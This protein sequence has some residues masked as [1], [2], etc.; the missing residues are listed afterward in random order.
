MKLTLYEPGELS[1]CFQASL[2]ES[3]SPLKIMATTPPPLDFDHQPGFEIPTKHKEAI[4]QLHGFAGKSVEELMAR[5]QLGKSTIN[6]IL[7]YEHPERARPSRTGRPRQLTDARVDEII[8]YLSETYE[9]RCL[10]WTHLRDELELSCT[11]EW[12]ATRLKQR[13]YF[14]CTACQKPYLTA[15]QVLGR[16]LWAITHIFWT[17]EWL[18][19]LWSDEVTFLVGGRTVKQK[20]TRKK[21]E[22]DCPTCIQHQFHRGH[23]T[24]VHAW[25]AIGYG[26]K[27]PLIFIQGSGKSGAFVQR[28]YLAQVLEAHLQPI[29]EAFAAITHLLRPVAEPLFMEDGNSAHGHKST[30]NCCAKW[31]TAHGIIL[32]PH[33]SISPDMNPIEKCWRRIKQALHRRRKQPTTVAE[34]QQIVLEEWDRIPQEWINQ[35]ILKQEHWVHVLMERHGWST[36]N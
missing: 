34:M 10:D 9:N 7:S 14:R 36:P 5:Y 24:P 33:P 23:T 1:L 2:S 16:F 20:V 8:E 25:G 18:K 11:P 28:N 3:H 13:G 35:L 15:A 21:G 26:Y 17:V 27:S 12:L 31:R 22:R 6:R 29:L 4:R 30:S 19:V 32:M